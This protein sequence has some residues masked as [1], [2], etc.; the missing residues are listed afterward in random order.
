MKVCSEHFHCLD[1][2]ILF[3][4]PRETVREEIYLQM[5]F[6]FRALQ[7]FVSLRSLDPSILFGDLD[8]QY[9]DSQSLLLRC[10]L[11]HILV[12]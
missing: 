7:T 2:C 12:T 9:L 11:V 5:V 8:I 6:Q 10:R 4:L 3:S 1:Q